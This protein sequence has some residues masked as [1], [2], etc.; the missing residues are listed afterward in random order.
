[1]AP[2]G[3]DGEH[4]L[5]STDLLTPVR[6]ARV[7]TVDR[8][9]T[10]WLPLAGVVNARDVGGLPTAD[11]GTVQYGRL[12]R[13]DN[14][15]QLTRGDVE[16]LIGPLGLRSVVDLR[17][18]EELQLE[19]PGPLTEVDGVRIHHLSLFPERGQR[20]DAAD[21]PA[22]E[23]LP[24]PVLPWHEENSPRGPRAPGS[25]Y[26]TYLFERPDS[27]LAA[28]RVIAEPDGATLVHCA[29]GKD[30]TGVVVALALSEVGVDRDAVVTD[31]VATSERIRDVLRRLAAT[32]TYARDVDA[33][34]F[35]NLDRHV[36]RATTMHTLLAQIDEQ[37]GGVRHWLRG[38]GW[39]ER[40]AAA[41]RTRLLDG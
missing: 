1:M 3:A 14:L 21:V 27:V 22:N 36:P 34:D 29:A 20:T 9:K 33:D 15:Q 12:Y 28:L 26:R 24:D 19:G 7:D 40:D 37:D 25:T 13:S 30:R 2:G 32:P 39:T 11:G 18:S 41:L 8:V 4:S 5:I 38:R 6:A 31:Y 35:D 10:A 16:A 17:T 23:P